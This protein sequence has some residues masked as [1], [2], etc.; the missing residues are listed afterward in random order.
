MCAARSRA[1]EQFIGG[2]QVRNSKDPI[3]GYQGIPVSMT[4]MAEHLRDAGYRTHLVGKWDAGMA[5]EAHSPR[6]RGYDEWLGCEN[7]RKPCGPY[8]RSYRLTGTD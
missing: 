5:T 3:S 1:L 2:L 4:G 8:W 6:S 7:Q